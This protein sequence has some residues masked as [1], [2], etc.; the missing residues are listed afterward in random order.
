MLFLVVSFHSNYTFYQYENCFFMIMLCQF[1]IALS[2]LWR[3]QKATNIAESIK[4]FKYI[5][6]S[7]SHHKDIWW[8]IKL[9]VSNV[10]FKLLHSRALIALDQISFANCIKE[11]LSC[12]I[13]F[14]RNLIFLSW[15]NDNLLH[16]WHSLN[17]SRNFWWR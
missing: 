7:C 1:Q 17:E 3:Y 14:E 4:S 16:K 8:A 12:H 5:E 11:F 15:C 13:F 2:S 9:R 10:T 6:G